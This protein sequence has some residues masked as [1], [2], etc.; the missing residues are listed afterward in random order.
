MWSDYPTVGF[1]KKW[2]VVQV[3]VFAY[4]GQRVRRELAIYVFNKAELYAGARSDCSR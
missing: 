3:N 2:I 4:P 1:N